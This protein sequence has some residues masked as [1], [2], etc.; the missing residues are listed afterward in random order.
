MTDEQIE[1]LR[2]AVQKEIEYATIDGME[3]AAWGW[4]SQE[5]EGSQSVD[6]ELLVEGWNNCISIIKGKLR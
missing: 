5:A 2:L 1:L 6:A 3:H 4:A